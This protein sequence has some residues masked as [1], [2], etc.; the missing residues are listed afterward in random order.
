MNLH[1]WRCCLCLVAIRNLG[2][3]MPY[4]PDRSLNLQAREGDGDTVVLALQPK[5]GL[6][7]ARFVFGRKMCIHIRFRQPLS[8]PCCLI[9]TAS[10]PESIFIHH[11]VSFP[12]P[13]SP[14]P[15]QKAVAM[16]RTYILDSCSVIPKPG[17]SPTRETER[18]VE[19]TEYENLGLQIHRCLLQ[20]DRASNTKSLETMMTQTTCVV[21]NDCH[22]R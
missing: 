21:K 10:L 11:Q 17:L 14:Y 3:S 22:T 7:L 13:S 6:S 15:S 8:R 20:V 12:T 5:A 19:R 2:W 9:L 4:V 18:H 1:I 16:W